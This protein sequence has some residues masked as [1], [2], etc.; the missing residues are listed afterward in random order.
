MIREI[1]ES[2]RPFPLPPA[3]LESTSVAKSPLLRT[4]LRRPGSTAALLSRPRLINQLHF[5]PNGYL[6]LLSA[7]AGFG[8]TTLVA[9]WARQQDFP[10][11]WLTL[12]EQDNDPILFWRY[13]IAAL[14][15]VNERIG[16]RAQAALAA[17]TRGAL[18]TA[19][20]LLINDIVEHTAPDTTLSLVL[21]DFHWIHTASIH[22]SLNF[23]LQH[24]P[25]QLHLLLLTRADPPLSLARLR[26]E[27]RLVE[28]RAT[29][30]R[31][32]TAEIA[33]FFTQVMTLDISEEDLQLLTQKT[34]GWAAGLQLV[35]LTLSQQDPANSAHV[36][37]LFARVKQHV[38]AYL[39]EEVL[40]YQTDE[41]RQ[42]LQ[43]TAVLRQFCGALCTAVTGQTNAEQI[44]HQ[45]MLGNLFITPLDD[46]GEW[47]RYHPLFAEMLRANLDTATQRECHRRAA[48]WYADQQLIQD[49][50]RN[51]LAAHDYPL[52]A[53]L[54]TRTY[55]TFLAQGLLVSLQK[56]LAALPDIHQSPRLRLA[57][58]WSQVYQSNEQ[59]L[60][61]LIDDI[62]AQQ[63][64]LDAAFQGEMLTVQANYAALYG[65]P[66][67]GIQLA[68]QAL[69]LID[70]GDFLCFAAT[71]QALGNAYRNLGRFDAALNAF[72]EARHQFEELGNV[73]M[74]QL[75]LYRITHIHIIQGRL[76]QA[77]QTYETAH[78]L[79]KAAGYEPL[80]ISGEIFGHLSDLFLEWNDLEQ[81]SAYAQQEITLARSGKLLLPL[82]DGYLKLAAVTAAQNNENEARQALQLA[83]ETA[84]QLQSTPL[85]AQIALHRA[86]HELTW[87]NLV[88]AG[89][90]AEQFVQQRHDGSCNLTPLLAQTADLLL[91]RIWLAQSQ[92]VKAL[93]LLQEI[94]G[95][96]EAAGRI[97]LVVEANVLQALAWNDQKETANAQKAL[98]HA[99]T[100]A[101][102]EGY[103]RL[104]VENGS[105]LA[106]LLNQVRHRFPE[107]ASQLLNAISTTVTDASTSPLLDPLTEREQEILELIAQGQTNRQIADVLFISVGTVKGHVNHIFSKL[108]VKNR[109]QALVQ[110]HELNLLKA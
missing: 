80:M 10:V 18:E 63:P 95:Q 1:P 11:A 108:D 25:P 58:A 28:L 61:Q 17:F 26:V 78:Q 50:M 53:A 73:F 20:T 64:Q 109:T 90:W 103:V 22:Q 24:Q 68:N 19:V 41:V 42:F 23:L 82:V 98:I 40:R 110:A 97:R 30:L 33:A 77:R 105:A 96:L 107:Y 2:E 88:A 12:D 29:D 46:E 76:H 51:A 48:N 52:M 92:P 83:A 13:L 86:R 81:A 15:V 9:E 8:K 89:A 38:F 91:A 74:A 14:Q 65:Q 99:L 6:T 70:P 54:L 3:S 66:E 100:L 71:Y 4:K 79:A 87:G 43:Q 57:A 44:L 104:F 102:P 75:P 5:Q 31:L 47:Y 35:A 37:Q 36:R 7:P 32:T 59:E 56:W 27:G 72:A 39:M 94:V 69:P 55:K 106:P 21:D 62:M 101:E 67:K 16:H 34:E 93:A 84:A 60:E 49:A 85:S 45:L